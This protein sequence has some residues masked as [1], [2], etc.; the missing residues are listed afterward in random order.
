MQQV[1]GHFQWYSYVFRG[2]LPF[3]PVH[4]RFSRYTP[5]FSGTH[6]FFTVRIRFFRYASV[7]G[8]TL[9]VKAG[10]SDFLVVRSDFQTVPM[11]FWQYAV[12]SR[13]Y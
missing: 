10:T 6:A 8:G 9:G 11:I 5:V 7:F 13:R 1:H 4:T 3:F 2:T 12:I